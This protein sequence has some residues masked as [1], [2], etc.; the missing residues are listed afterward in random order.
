MRTR[1]TP[2]KCMNN[3]ELDCE[4]VFS[5]AEWYPVFSVVFDRDHSVS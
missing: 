4:T 1:E 3:V 5:L 2:V